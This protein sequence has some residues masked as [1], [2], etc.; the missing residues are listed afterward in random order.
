MAGRNVNASATRES[1]A[2]GGKAKAEKLR[3]E[4]EARVEKAQARFDTLA[5]K[6]ISRL[7][8]LLDSEDHAVV[9]RAAKEILDRSLGKATQRHEHGGQVDV[10]V[11]VAEV[12]D[13]LT[14]RL[15]DRSSRKRTP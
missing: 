13:R 7:E 11:E 5:D 1:R 9:V 15:A 2:K 8:A 3:A 4:R 14:A 10:T 12:R 6:A